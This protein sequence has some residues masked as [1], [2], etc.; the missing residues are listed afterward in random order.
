MSS[1]VVAV[2]LSFA[3]TAV[4][5]VV[6]ARFLSVKF[7]EIGITGIDVHKRDKPVTARWAGSAVLIGVVAGASL[8]YELDLG[9][10]SL[11]LAGLLTI[12]LVGMVGNG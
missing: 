1:I 11:F 6:L 9:F 2:S 10:S 12:L 4:V 3:L 7:K 5:T 8:F